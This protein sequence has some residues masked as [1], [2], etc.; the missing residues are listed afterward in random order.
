MG[1][2]GV[3]AGRARLDAHDL[4]DL[5]EGEVGLV[6]QVDD[7]ALAVGQAVDLR[8]DGHPLGRVDL[9]HPRRRP[10][11]ETGDEAGDAPVGGGARPWPGARA[12]R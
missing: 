10:V 12:V 3:G 9:H 5:L 7:L 6:A 1:G 8:P 4:A 2:G 11:A